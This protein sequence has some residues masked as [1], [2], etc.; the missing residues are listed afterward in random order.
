MHPKQSAVA[1]LPFI[2]NFDHVSAVKT[3]D[4]AEVGPGRLPRQVPMREATD[5]IQWCFY[6]PAVV[7]PKELEFSREQEATITESLEAYRRAT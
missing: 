7:D 6:F 2:V 4:A 1:G 5:L 3:G